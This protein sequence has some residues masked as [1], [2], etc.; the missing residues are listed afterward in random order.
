MPPNSEI[1]PLLYQGEAIIFSDQPTTLFV[2]TL[3]GA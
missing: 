3:A 1:E 2:L